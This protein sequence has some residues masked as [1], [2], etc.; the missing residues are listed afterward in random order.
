MSIDEAN[1]LKNEEIVT[2]PLNKEYLFNRETFI[3]QSYLNT[4]IHNPNASITILNNHFLSREES[5]NLLNELEYLVTKLREKR[6]SFNDK[7][8]LFCCG[9]FSICVVIFLIVFYIFDVLK[10][11]ETCKKSKKAIIEICEAPTIGFWTR[12][13]I[14]S[15]C[16]LLLIFGLYCTGSTVVIFEPFSNKLTIDK[17]KLFCLPSICEYPLEQ[18]SHACIESD[19]SDGTLNLSTFY[20]Y[21]VTLVF[22]NQNEKVVNLGLGR[23]CFFLQ[24]KIE[25]VNSINKYLNAIKSER[26]Y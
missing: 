25:L 26:G 9:C 7:S 10:Y 2:L 8:R 17:K 15:I 14:I 3:D 19:S 4:N 23:D 5:E 12:F 20:F 11:E 1:K 13:F 18:L 16:L 24:E 22:T 21:S 6:R